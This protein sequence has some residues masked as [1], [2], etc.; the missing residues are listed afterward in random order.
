MNNHINITT[1]LASLLLVLTSCNDRATETLSL[2]GQNQTELL[3]VIDHYAKNGDR[4]KQEAAMFLIE[5][6]K[7]HSYVESEAV[8][9]FMARVRSLDTDV[10]ADSLSRIW[11][12]VKQYDKPVVRLD[13]KTITCRM[14]VDNIDRAMAR[15][16]KAAW[17]DNVDFDK[18]CR[19]ILPYRMLDEQLSEGWRD[20]LYNEY[21]PIIEG[22]KDMKKAFYLVHNAV[23]ERFKR[24]PFDMVYLADILKLRKIGHGSCVQHCIYEAAVMRALALPVAVDGIEAWANYSKNGHMWV[25]LIADDGTYTVAKNDSVARKMNYIDS[26]VFEMKNQPEADYPYNTGFKKRCFKINRYTYEYNDVKYA[27]NETDKMTRNHFTQPWTVDVTRDYMKCHEVEITTDI[28]AEYA[29]LCTFRTG[30]GWVPAV[31]AKRDNGRFVFH[32]MTDSVMYLP[33]FSKDGKMLP[34]SNPFFLTNGEKQIVCPKYDEKT[35]MKLDR[36]Y[37]LTPHF[38]SYWPPIRGARFEA[39]N[40]PDFSDADVLHVVQETPLMV[41]Y[42]NVDSKKRYRY[43]RYVSPENKNPGIS[44]L[45]LS[46]KGKRIAGMPFGDSTLNDMNNAFDGDYLTVTEAHVPFS[47]GM[48]FGRTVNIDKLMFSPKTDANFIIPGNKY[49]LLYYDMGWKTLGVKTAS[50]NVMEYYDAPSGALYILRNRTTGNEERI[51]SYDNGQQ[52]WW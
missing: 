22:V 13:A 47:F 3:E 32:D 31:F 27:D 49:E 30:R 34:I 42:V 20:T 9:S 48:D 40:T 10:N 6:M 26:S 24:T 12:T 44:E 2:A 41:N 51:F 35:E 11:A 29:Y 25:A 28:N 33:V 5:N 50:S 45:Q 38:I 36:K 15:W 17:R 4:G 23:S 43:V 46:Y 1:V 18:F 14:L 21:H 52:I 19:Y 39:A 16:Q 8:D 7:N 37:P